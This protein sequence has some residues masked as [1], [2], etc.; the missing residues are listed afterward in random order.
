MNFELYEVWA[1]DEAGH[2]EL[3][4]TTSSRKEALEIATTANIPK[5]ERRHLIFHDLVS[6]ISDRVAGNRGGSAMMSP[7]QGGWAELFWNQKVYS[8]LFDCAYIQKK[9]IGF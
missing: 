1:V 2:E 5:R 3:V 7:G 8:L 9:F 6:F 4:E